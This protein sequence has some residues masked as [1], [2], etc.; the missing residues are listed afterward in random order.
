MRFPDNAATYNPITEFPGRENNQR[1]DDCIQDFLTYAGKELADYNV[2]LSADVFGVITHSWN[3]EPDDIGQTWRKISRNVDVICPM[4]Y[5]SHYDAGWYGYDVPDQEPYGVFNQAMKEALERNESQENVPVIRHWVQGFNASWVNG[6]REYTP[7][8]I[9]EQIVAC[10]ELGIDEYLVWNAENHYDPMTFFYHDQ[11]KKIMSDDQDAVGRTADEVLDMYLRAQKKQDTRTEY[12]LTPVANRPSEYDDF[13]KSIK[14]I[15]RK[16]F[17]YEVQ[18]FSQN[19]DGGY[20]A[21]LN[22]VYNSLEG[23]HYMEEEP[24]TILKENGI[25]KV[26]QIYIR[27]EEDE[28]EP[29]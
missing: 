19:E 24:V 22:G 14:D 3:D 8:V 9:A 20:T 16:L 1:K 6:Y 18:E 13:I 11:V 15:N 17:D 21:V 25:W 5:P 29:E 7:E 28:F 27:Y 26:F 12:L 23:L 4:I 10:Q 2:F